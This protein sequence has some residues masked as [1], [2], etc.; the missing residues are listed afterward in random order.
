MSRITQMGLVVGAIAAWSTVLH[1]DEV[2]YV[3]RES[4][5]RFRQGT[6]EASSPVAAW[7]VLGFD[8]EGW[9]VGDAPFGYG[10]P[11]LAT[12]LAALDPPM[13]QNYS[14]VFLRTT[15]EVGNAGAVDA[16][17][18]DVNYDDGII[19][20]IN[21]VEV[22]RLNMPGSPGDTIAVDDF[23]TQA[24]PDE[25]VFRLEVLPD[26]AGYLQN[27]TNV[28]AIMVFNNSMTSSD[29][30][31]DIDL[32][33]PDGID[34][35]PPTLSQVVPAG[36][37]TVRALDEIAVTFGEFVTGI[38]AGD[39]L[40][41]G[42]PATGVSGTEEGPYVF[43]LPALAAGA[44]DVSFAPGH[45]IADVS[46]PPN[47]F[48]G[49]EWS[50]TIDPD[51]PAA[52]LVI[53][54]IVASNHGSSTDEDGDSSDWFE[55]FNRGAEP[56]DVAG[57]S[58]SDDVDDPDRWVLPSAMIPPQ[59]YLLV[60]ASG[61]DRTSGE[62]HANFELDADGE[63][64]GLWS[65]DSPRALL[66]SFTP[67]YP[68]QR[69]DI[70]WGL[71]GTG[72]PAY[73]DNPTPGA[74]NDLGSTLDGIVPEPRFNVERGWYDGG[75]DLEIQAP[76]GATVRYRLDSS[77]PTPTSGTV[78][79][80][81]IAIA[82]TAGA[83][84]RVVRAVAYRSGYV[85]SRVVTHTYV[86]PEYVGRQPARPSGFPST[87]GG[88][89]A[90]Y[91]MDPDI[92]D[93]GRYRDRFLEGLLSIPTVSL[94][95][96]TNE[97]FGSSGIYSNATQSGSNWERAASME[98][99]YPP[100]F[101]S[102]SGERT[103]HVDCALRMQGGASRNHSRSPKHSFRVLFKGDYGP[104]KFRRRVFPE[105]T[106]TRDFDT[107]T[108]RAGYNN[109]WVHSNSGQRQ[110]CQYIR[111]Q[112]AR[113]AQIDMGQVSSHG[114]YVHL[115]VNGL[116]W[117]VYN[118]VERPSAP[119]AAAYLGGDKEEYDA[120]NSASPVDGNG[121]A[122]STL[123][124]RVR[125]DL[126]SDAN[127]RRV[128]EYLDIDSFVDYMLVNL[129][130][131]NND[132]PHHNWYGARKRENGAKWHF[133]SW[134]AERILEG[135]S[136]NKIGVSNDNS[137]GIIWARLR[138]SAE[139]R[140]RAADRI[141]RHF[142]NNGSL[143]P[144]RIEELWMDRAAF[145]ELA[146]VCESARWGDYRAS[147]PYAPDSHWFPEQS[148]LLGSYFPQRSTNVFNQLRS[149]GLYPSVGA[150]VF[151]R[152]GGEV[153]RGFLLTISRPGGTGGTIYVTLD[154]S[155][156]RVEFSGDITASAFA[157]DS[158]I[159]LT[160]PTVV[161]ARIRSGSN[162]S[163]LTEASFTI[164][165]YWDG[166]LISEIL[167]HAASG[168]AYEFVEVAN[169]GGTDVDLA[170][171]RFAD[172][173]DFVWD[174]SAT[175]EPGGFAVV[176][177][178]AASFASRYPGISIDGVYAGNLSGGGERIELVD[179]AGGVL[180]EVEYNDAG[181]WPISP[182]G[183]GHS[184]VL[185]D[186]SGRRSDPH[187]WRASAQLHGSP[188]ELD[189]E[190]VH[191][192]VVIHEVLSRSELPFEDAVEL[193]NPTGEAIDISGWY[194]SD[195]RSNLA[196][197]KKYR[198][199]PGT[200][201]PA[202]DYLVVYEAELN[203][204]GDP[205]RFA[206]NGSGDQV[207][208]S[209]AD[210]LGDLTGYIVGVDL[211]AFDDGVS[212]GRLDTSVGPD[213]ASLVAPT[214]GVESP[215][216]VEEFRD[217]E[218]AENA[219]PLVGPIVLNEIMYH[220]ITGGDEFIELHNLTETEIALHDAALGRGWEL[221]GVLDVDTGASYSFPPGAS[222]GGN[223]FALV[224]PMAPETFRAFYDVPAA[225]PIY[226]PYDGGLA[227]GGERLRLMR[228]APEEDDELPYVLVDK[229]V[230]DDVTP[231]PSVADGEGPSLERRVPQ[232]YGNE[233]RNW[234]ASESDGGTPGRANSIGPPPPNQVPL[235]A[236]TMLPQQGDAP[237][238]VRFDAAASRDSDGDIVAYSWDFGDGD[239]A[240]GR[241]ITHTFEA[242]GDYQVTLTV[243][244][245]GGLEDTAS[246]TVRVRT[247]N[248]PPIASFTA[249]PTTGMAP[250]TVT[251][252]ASGSDD[253]DGTIGTYLWDFGDGTGDTGRVVQHEF[254][255][256]G[257]YTIRLIVVDDEGAEG[258]T[259]TDLTIL[260][261]QRGG[262]YPGDCNQDSRLDVSDAV[263]LLGH[264]F[265]GRPDRLP[266]GDGTVADSGNGVL[267]N[268]NTDAT[269]DLADAVYLLN[270]LFQGGPP[271]VSGTECIPV[272][273]C[274]D[275]CTP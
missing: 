255:D 160:R 112:W 71:D 123:L 8:V 271:P 140:L 55:I 146:T 46:D 197:L 208:L 269:V 80:G 72:S 171:V 82:G 56:V 109:S 249:D 94:A 136:E 12:D 207:Y 133:F 166:L 189:P 270:Y 238:T 239:S 29:L 142:F 5:W 205:N 177:A 154:G 254:D 127:Y 114:T 32:F 145:I 174:E 175:I 10:D 115:Y 91:A 113:D 178:D 132:W 259:Q 218:G 27:G 157:Y 101:D 266:C 159:E 262:Q 77:E 209:S 219:A 125:A 187:S 267:L 150:P 54:E 35:T 190:P 86:F 143:T 70:S 201:I 251:F 93:S 203:A 66:S 108:F 28:L 227:N 235:A 3:E 34:V 230:F 247:S 198:F 188:G 202:A 156:P 83:A 1:A 233:P 118:L 130:G 252:D 184:L 186:P 19:G 78:Y 16:L 212:Y 11:P 69:A 217:G 110:R 40:V 199:E 141:H 155:D 250:L 206:L 121:S 84:V 152:H 58:V 228:P 51:A 216:T 119:F 68:A 14:S 260:G 222:I 98:V 226:G 52:D 7:R 232:D 220:P 38:D 221:R 31:F 53:N 88:F 261:E 105:A 273:G 17:E 85:P 183:F 81:P 62:L 79:G 193:W 102:P 6:S 42:L 59:G 234:G 131:A 124:S 170:G 13:R 263:C 240:I 126:S 158:P 257:V 39:L 195:D 151:A 65:A 61:K 107:L 274:P 92:V 111:D 2:V 67:R 122:W 181:Q 128:V 182:D 196:T 225:V 210:G 36:G 134:D 90:D 30:H 245:D 37:T 116:Y 129:Y 244:D 173:I 50:Y 246:G 163:A 265:V 33:D 248:L 95:G 104:S 241:T 73:F 75:F 20:W 63:F 229:V 242:G 153:S 162:W 48:E 144:G 169:L 60:F 99:M 26:P 213:Y 185:A 237:L 211:P 24:I 89:T 214:F 148:R 139:F 103:L 200:V 49:V 167:Y 23:A 191:G 236:F 179:P 100:G 256:E 264:L 275:A 45:G 4:S 204:E 21:G 137:P 272:A 22:L 172:G 25:G 164:P 96:N 76:P 97:I 120:L 243:R 87:W 43:T 192:G 147:T 57:Y 18:A 74:A 176:A 9:D 258:V 223:G 64:L 161:K 15:F 44:V 41:N 138:S 268:L 165:G 215:S 149:A 168:N 180:D 224:V 117:G 106:A 231:W 47:G 135:V 253:P 194:L